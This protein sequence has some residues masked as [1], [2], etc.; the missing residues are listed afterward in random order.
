MRGADA[1]VAALEAAGLPM[2][3]EEITAG[4]TTL[5]WEFNTEEPRVSVAPRGA[6]RRCRR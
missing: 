4:G 1:V 2:H 5:G 3:E 6:W